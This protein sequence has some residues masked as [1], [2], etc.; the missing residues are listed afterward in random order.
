MARVF[1][2]SSA[3]SI[4]AI[5]FRPVVR[6]GIVAETRNGAKLSYLVAGKHK[7]EEGG[8]VL[9][10]PFRCICSNPEPRSQVSSFHGS[11]QSASGGQALPHGP[12]DTS[13]PRHGPPMVT[14]S[15]TVRTRTALPVSLLSD[16]SPAFSLDLL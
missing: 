3:W 10:C 1:G 9:T 4:V 5:D 6:Q 15:L 14:V 2:S 8:W 16:V 13:A 11:P 7:G 12:G